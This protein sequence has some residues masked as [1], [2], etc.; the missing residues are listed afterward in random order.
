MKNITFTIETTEEL[1][2]VRYEVFNGKDFN[3]CNDMDDALK[4]IKEL[5]EIDVNSYEDFRDEVLN[6]G[7]L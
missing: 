1:V 7:W 5:N 2:L 4:M 3:I 6:K